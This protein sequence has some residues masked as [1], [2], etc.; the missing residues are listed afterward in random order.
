MQHYIKA[1]FSY[2][3]P[4][5]APA[6]AGINLLDLPTEALS[7]IFELLE[8][9]DKRSL[10]N[11][12]CTCRQFYHIGLPILYREFLWP[13][14]DE[15]LSPRHLDSLRSPTNNG[16]HYIKCLHFVPWTKYHQQKHSLTAEQKASLFDNQQAFDE[17]LSRLHKDQL[18]VL[19]FDRT[20]PGIRQKISI[21]GS[22]LKSQ[23]QIQKLGLWVSPNPTRSLIGHKPLQHLTE[24]T[25]GAERGMHTAGFRA[26]VA[27]ITASAGTLKKLTLSDIGVGA[28]WPREIYSIGYDHS[29]VAQ[30]GWPDIL[31]FGDK[32]PKKDETQPPKPKLT[33]LTSFEMIDFVSPDLYIPHL[34]VLFDVNKLTH[35]RMSG[36]R[37]NPWYGE[38]LPKFARLLTSITSLHLEG[39]SAWAID[40]TLPSVRP[41]TVLRV[42]VEDRVPMPSTFRRHKETLKVF[43]LRTC[44]YVTCGSL[45][46]DYQIPLW[47]RLEIL[48][49]TVQLSDSGNSGKNHPLNPPFPSYQRTYP[50]KVEP[51]PVLKLPMNL[52]ALHILEECAPD[53]IGYYLF[54]SSLMDLPPRK[55]QRPTENEID[56]HRQ[57][58]LKLAPTFEFPVTP[59]T[60][61][62]P[63]SA[64]IMG[65]K[66]ANGPFH[67]MPVYG[68]GHDIL[69]WTA[70]NFEYLVSQHPALE[71]LRQDKIH[72][73]SSF[74]DVT[75]RW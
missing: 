38:T 63:L 11:I 69:S 30:S 21:W 48:A 26:V 7:Q 51:R 18:Q 8:D 52:R 13:V 62:P 16:V 46:D 36:Y 28:D 70:T 50:D 56:Y 23:R 1:F 20:T 67:F 57:R 71:V 64:L 19:W 45:N 54:K 41:L 42:S 24:L 2:F 9:R 75:R 3:F 59:L 33:A 14:S 66:P 72:R 27:W 17:A 65:E 68:E 74:R 44:D 43:W 34:H 55:N 32:D 10:A 40:N 61:K 39:F 31:F 12:C 6:A 22:L 4:Q 58:I 35:F 60:W 73:R 29:P 25:I 47:P 53:R 15:F 49:V 37:G 5:P